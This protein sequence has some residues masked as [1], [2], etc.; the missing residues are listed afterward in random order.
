MGAIRHERTTA[1]LIAR[2]SNLVLWRSLNR[3]Q[4]IA[5][6]PRDADCGRRDAKNFIARQHRTALT[7]FTESVAPYTASSN[8]VTNTQGEK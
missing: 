5:S 3:Q 2:R 4:G 1:K 8:S 6:V 7:P